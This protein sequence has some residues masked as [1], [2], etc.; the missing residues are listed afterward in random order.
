MDG[1]AAI[2]ETGFANAEALFGPQFL[3]RNRDA[4]GLLW[5]RF[6]KLEGVAWGRRELHLEETQ[7]RTKFAAGVARLADE[8]R[9]LPSTI[10]FRK[11][12]TSLWKPRST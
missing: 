11:D 6:E 9:S 8:L 1:K 3:K 10:Q 7:F 12:S 2:S 5:N 4:L